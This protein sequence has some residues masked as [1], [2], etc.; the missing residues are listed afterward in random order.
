MGES[1]GDRREDLA[2]RDDYDPE[3][4]K[5]ITLFDPERPEAWIRVPYLEGSPPDFSDPAT[6]EHL[7][8]GEADGRGGSDSRRS[9]SRF[10]IK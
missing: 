4:R 5:W 10:R 2:V 6:W 7:R 3:G 1:E 9:G 8:R